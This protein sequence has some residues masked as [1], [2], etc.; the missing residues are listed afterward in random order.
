MPAIM[1]K[2]PLNV[3]WLIRWKMAAN[4]ANENNASFTW[5]VIAPAPRSD[6]IKPSW[7][8]VENARMAFK[9]VCFTAKSEPQNNVSK[10]IPVTSQIHTS[11]TTKI[12]VNRATRYN[13]ALTI[14]AECKYAL[15]GVGAT[16]ASGNQM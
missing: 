15:T 4:I 10:P 1:N 16:I 13:P 14:V 11:D 7:L 6:M 2:L 8:T 3:A 9:S 5:N 12:G